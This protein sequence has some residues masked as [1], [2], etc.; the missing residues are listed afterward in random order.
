MVFPVP[1]YA[2]PAV[3]DIGFLFELGPFEAQR[4]GFAESASWV[5]NAFFWYA[6]SRLAY[7][8]HIHISANFL[9]GKA[10][11]RAKDVGGWVEGRTAESATRK[12][13]CEAEAEAGSGAGDAGRM[14]SNS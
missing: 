12:G 11:R 9:P 6:T 8:T 3:L 5:E 13:K 10:K 7:H 4:F 2:L 1:Q 14:G